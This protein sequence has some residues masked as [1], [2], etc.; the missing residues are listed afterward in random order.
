[1]AASLSLNGR[2]SGS[3][4]LA[5]TPFGPVDLDRVYQTLEKQALF[6]SLCLDD[7]AWNARRH[8]DARED[9]DVELEDESENSPA[10]N[11]RKRRLRGTRRA[12]PGGSVSGTQAEAQAARSRRPFLR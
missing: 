4:S 10:I 8:G 11:G 6:L 5:R 9:D 1:M 12:R 7:Q 3:P 2:R